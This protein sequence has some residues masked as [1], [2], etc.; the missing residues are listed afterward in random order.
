MIK[1][2]QTIRSVEALRKQVSNWRADGCSIGLVPTMGALHAGHLSLV[3][4][5]K[6]EADKV[7]ASI[8]VNPTQFGPNEDYDE[9]PRDD[10]ADAGKL[11]QAGVDAVFIPPITE[12]YPEDF[13]T[14]VRVSGMTDI[15][16]G[17]QRHSHFDGVALIV[18]KLLL[19]CLPDLAV[20]G[21][22]DY[23][24]LQIIRRF[25]AD[26]DIPVRVLGGPIVREADN[27]ALSSRNR[28]LTPEE[29]AIAAHFPT[30]LRST[31][32]SIYEG[33]PLKQSLNAAFEEILNAGFDSVDYIELRNASDLSE[34]T[35]LSAPVRLFGAARVGATR[36]ID[37][38]PVRNPCLSEQ[39]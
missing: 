8:F 6:R 36:L 30:I 14:S 5:A 31:V 22:K 2:L 38:W 1:I 13:A 20:F 16:C 24:Q 26:L 27:L 7:V 28:Y 33:A 25:V 35:D 21:K 23:Q 9:Y 18:T 15:L 11:E 32:A 12:M 17:A 10:A 29:R 3:E 19:Q 4:L 34:A 37:N 39:A